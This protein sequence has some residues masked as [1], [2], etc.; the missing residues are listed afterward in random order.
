LIAGVLVSLPLTSTVA[1]TVPWTDTGSREQVCDLIW[2][3]LLVAAPIVVLFIALPLLRT[4][5][6]SGSRCRCRARLWCCLRRKHQAAVTNQPQL[7]R[8]H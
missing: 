3:I 6:I 7:T 8:R 4:G 2:S 5:C 1:L